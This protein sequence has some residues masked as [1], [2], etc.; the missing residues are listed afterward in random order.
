MTVRKLIADFLDEQF[1]VNRRLPRTITPLLFKPG[2][3]TNDYFEG[4]IQQY[5]P[6]FKLYL[7][8]SL[9]FFAI[10]AA[11]QSSTVQ[12][13]Q[14]AAE[15]AE[16]IESDTA[17]QRRMGMGAR[18]GGAF[19]GVQFDPRDTA[20]WLQNPDVNLFYP[21]LSRAAEKRI[22]EFAVFGQIEGTR[23]LINAVLAQMPTVIFILLPLYAFLLWLFYR[24]QRRYYVEHFVFAMHLH[25]FAFLA[26]LPMQ[27]L[28]FSFLPKWLQQVGEILSPII[29]LAIL[30]YI[31]IA[32]KRVY[33]QRKLMIA[34][35]F[36]FLTI[37]YFVILGF[38]VILAFALALVIG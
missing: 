12:I 23:R 4:R 10:F 2:R 19:I 9:V 30:V 31:F 35:K 18:T 36:F 14:A 24:R 20:N 1:G 7:V 21:P 25:S 34:A 13:T 38:G 27:L 28:E 8:T 37:S 3:L 17:A 29:L 33:R 5:I 26:M 15:A 22:R 11:T 16:E 6:P 32:M